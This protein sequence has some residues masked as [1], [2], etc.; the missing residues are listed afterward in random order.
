MNSDD[1]KIYIKIVVFDEIYKFV[2]QFFFPF[3][4]IWRLKN[5]IYYTD[6]RYR[7][8]RSGWYIIFWGH[9]TTLNEKSLNYKML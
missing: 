5:T 7:K 1:D 8:L 3:E 6:L 9:E 4:I 2:V